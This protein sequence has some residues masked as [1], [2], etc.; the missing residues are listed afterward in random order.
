M[1]NMKLLANTPASSKQA[2]EFFKE[3]L[4]GEETGKELTNIQAGKVNKLVTKF[5]GAGTGADMAGQTYWG[6]LNAITEQFTHGSGRRDPSHQF[7]DNFY[8]N[9]E[10]VKTATYSKAMAVAVA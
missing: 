8:G 5:E 4:F 6:I 7:W 9:G 3:T 2:F 1:N 10:K